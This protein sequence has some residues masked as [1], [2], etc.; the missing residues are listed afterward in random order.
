MCHG[1]MS[2]V[3]N[4]RYILY[5]LRNISDP[6]DIFTRNDNIRGIHAMYQGV[7]NCYIMT[8]KHANE[9]R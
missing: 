2:S 6:D 8:D 5:L 3:T 9:L 7:N 1:L 4:Y